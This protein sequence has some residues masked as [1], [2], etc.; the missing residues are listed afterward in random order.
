MGE[1]G[2]SVDDAAFIESV[3]RSMESL[4]EQIFKLAEK[5]GF[6]VVNEAKQRTPVRTGVLRAAWKMRSERHSEGGVIEVSNETEYGPYIEYGTKPHTITAK[7]A[8]VLTDGSNFFGQSVQHPGTAP[9]PMLA[10]AVAAVE[11][12]LEEALRRLK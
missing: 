10:P 9:K 12:K 3:K 7:N 4:G 8:K 11:P 6:E 1:T 5:G 2:M